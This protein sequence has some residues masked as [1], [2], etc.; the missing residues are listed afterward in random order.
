M[1]TWLAILVPA[2]LVLALCCYWEP[3]LGD[4]WGH[5]DYQRWAGMSL[6]SLW[7]VAKYDY[8]SGN[9][10]LGQFLTLFLFTPIHAI[11]TPLVELAMFAQL[12]ALVLGRW[13][14]TRDDALLFLTIVA[15]VVTCTPLVGPMLFYRPYTGNYLYGL[16]IC[17]AF[18][19]PYRC[20]LEQPRAIPADGVPHLG[21]L[22]RGP[23]MFL[24]GA[25]AGM[26]NEHTGPACLALAVAACIYVRRPP[27]WMIAGAVGFLAGGLALYFAPG[28]G[29]RYSGLAQQA[30]LLGRIIGR[31]AGNLT[32]VWLF[33]RYMIYAL[34]WVALALATRARAKP[35]R[36][37]VTLALAGAGLLVTLTL[38]AS[39][40]QGE[41]LY[42]AAIAFAATALASWIVPQLTTP[43]ARRAGWALAAAASLYVAVRCISVYYVIGREFDERMALIDH[44]PQGGSVTVPHYTRG[45]SHW[46]LGDDFDAANKRQEV[47]E[48]Y[49]LGRIDVTGQRD[50]S[51][52]GEPDTP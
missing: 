24:L 3:V 37:A 1:K 39:P 19:L 5:V 13:P 48:I 44:T 46:F 52:G 51:T 21:S 2:W 16:V 11:V 29:V 4:G 31:G 6:H 23:A 41:R 14:R 15:L 25:A 32:I 17:L 38:L 26:C 40:K 18:L 34:P 33:V 9:P 20:H 43:W 10:R 28:Q 45:H 42:A 36:P 35:Q 49:H 22:W 8:T 30:S 47:A 12:T 50:A 27:A 7:D